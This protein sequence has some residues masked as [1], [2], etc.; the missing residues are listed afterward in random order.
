MNKAIGK[1][2]FN[3]KIVITNRDNV[4]KVFRPQ[5]FDSI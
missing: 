1:I 3:N 5:W 2:G 4:K